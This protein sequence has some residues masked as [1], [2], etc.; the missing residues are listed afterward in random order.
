M[1]KSDKE[2]EEEATEKNNKLPKKKRNQYYELK[3]AIE[4]LKLINVNQKDSKKLLDKAQERI[5]SSIKMFAKMPSSIVIEQIAKENPELKQKLL[6]SY[7]KEVASFRKSR[8]T[9]EELTSLVKTH[10]LT[11]DK[12]K[13][14]EIILEL[15]K[16][17]N[18]DKKEDKAMLI[19]FEKLYDTKVLDGGN[20][21]D[22]PELDRMFEKLPPQNLG[23]LLFREA[24]KDKSTKDLQKESPVKGEH[25]SKLEKA[26]ALLQ[27]NTKNPQRGLPDLSDEQK[28]SAV[29]NLV[30]NLSLKQMSKV[31]ATVEGYENYSQKNWLSKALTRFAD[32]ICRRFSDLKTKG[33]EAGIKQLLK[34]AG[35][36]NEQSVVKA[37]KG[38]VVQREKN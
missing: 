10:L 22:M 27:A 30:S 11:D 28:Q 20:K 8:I 16:G 24:Y 2:L 35:I 33:V 37:S 1:S 12:V 18:F 5:E 4:E 19:E 23:K 29:T 38:K 26:V 25:H 13:N 3:D 32:G 21:V 15:T 7:A 17:L 31:V 6:M 34:T 36:E 9:P 14:A